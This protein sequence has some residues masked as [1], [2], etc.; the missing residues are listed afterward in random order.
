MLPVWHAFAGVQ[1]DPAAQATHA[2]EPQTWFVPQLVPLASAV[3]RSAHTS[4]PVA[5][6][7]WPAWHG[8]PAGVHTLPATQAPHTP[9]W[10][11]RFEPQA[12]PSARA[13]PLSEQVEAPVAQLVVPLWHGLAGA[14]PAPAMQV[15]QA[16]FE[17]TLLA[18]QTVPSARFAPLSAQAA[19]PPVH[20]IDPAW[21]ELA[22]W[23][24][25]PAVQT[26]VQVPA[27]QTWLGP[28]LTRRAQT[29]R[30]RTRASPWRS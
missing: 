5:Q 16:P 20:E 19:M 1:A 25:M 24:D 28:Q 3:P 15:L 26:S 7:V 29:R 21:H 23:H 30:P 9:V 18:P 6:L 13:R 12:V 17:H 10:Q 14:Q 8:K 11:A 4:R 27:W 2:P 22:G